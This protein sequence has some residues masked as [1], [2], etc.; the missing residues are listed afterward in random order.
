VNV[1]FVISGYLISKSYLNN[2]SFKIYFASRA[3]RIFPGLIVVVLFAAWVVGPLFTQLPV[4]EY[5]AHPRTWSY[6]ENIS[7][8]KLQDTLPGVFVGV[9]KA[10][11]EQKVNAP[12]WTL[13]FEFM[14]YIVVFAY[15]ALGLLKKSRAGMMVQVVVYLVMA[16]S[17]FRPDLL[18][19]HFDLVNR[20]VNLEVFA[21]FYVYFFTGVW[22]MYFLKQVPLKW[23]IGVA[24]VLLWIALRPTL[25]FDL[26]SLVTVSYLVF[27]LAYYPKP[28]GAVITRR[29]D[30]SYGIYI[31]GYIVQN[32][33]QLYVGNSI[34]VFPK[35]LLMI[36]CTVPFAMASWFLIEK[37]A[38]ALKKKL[39]T[40]LGGSLPAGTYPV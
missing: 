22:L 7:L 30:F 39:A 26:I 15:G 27:Y 1:F 4:M 36:A 5:L 21:K 10:G 29:G 18:R 2:P 32:I 6:L 37:K 28:L 14:M 24:L 34:P 12:L 33:V 9:T 40:P 3:L 25:L 20:F 17:L 19:E 16:V 8:I 23:Y 31:Y 35:A 11:V 38:L 13:V